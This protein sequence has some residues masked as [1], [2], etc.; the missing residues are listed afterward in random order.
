MAKA[1]THVVSGDRTQV[2]AALARAHSE[3][4]LVSVTSSQQL[5]GGRVQVVV[6]LLAVRSGWE[7]AKP[8]LIG[9]AKTAAAVVGVAGVGGLIWLLVLAVMA[10]VAWVVSVVAWVTAHLVGIIVCF[11]LTFFLLVWLLSGNDCAGI[12]CRGCRR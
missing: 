9:T 3:G 2:L 4:R 8:W 10:V 1:Q 12:H 7:K 6:D 5:P 11:W